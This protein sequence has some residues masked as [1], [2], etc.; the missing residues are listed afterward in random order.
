VTQQAACPRCS[1]PVQFVAVYRRPALV[2]FGRLPSVT[3]GD[4]LRAPG[5]A[6]WTLECAGGHTWRRTAE[7]E[8]EWGEAGAPAVP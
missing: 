6:R 8:R 3:S 5:N 7:F 4:E 2:G 1:A